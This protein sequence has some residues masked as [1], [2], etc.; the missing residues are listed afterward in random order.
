MPFSISIDDLCIQM[1]S[2][3]KQMG[4]ELLDTKCGLEINNLDVARFTTRLRAGS[5]AVKQSQYVYVQ[6]R[7]MWVLTLS[8]D[9]TQWAK[10]Q[11]VF[12]TIA[13]SFRVSK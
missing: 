11:P 12:D 6:G 13:E 5:L 9:E 8:V 10:Y 2:A 1:P 4:I 7:N 3:Y